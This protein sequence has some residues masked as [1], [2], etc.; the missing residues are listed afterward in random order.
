MAQRIRIVVVPPALRRQQ[1][2]GPQE[3]G[4]VVGDVPLAARVLQA[5]GHPAK[6]TAALEYLSQ[7][8]RT[9]VAGQPIAPAL[10]PK[11]PVETGRG[12]F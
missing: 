9:R 5:G 11:R 8:H 4:E 12:R 2:R 3:R 1:D 10:D 6:D 7:H